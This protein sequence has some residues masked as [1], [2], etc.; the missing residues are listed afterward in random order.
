MSAENAHLTLMLVNQPKEI[1]RACTV[2]EEFVAAQRLSGETG[3]AL[4]LTL[5]EVVANVIRHGY[6]DDA[7]HII[8]VRLW[9]EG[10]LLSVQVAD[11]GVAFNPLLAPD[12]DLTLPIEQ[13]PVGGLGIHI[14]RTMMDD[15]DY[16]RA[17]G[18]NLL[19][20]RKRV[21][22]VEPDSVA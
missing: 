6:D 5:D 4:A 14:I 3:Y 18:Q 8:R 22:R 1:E 16:R 7:E 10:D 19:T 2:V 15:I 12:P 11:D 20:L 21:E 13:R 9:L 17:N